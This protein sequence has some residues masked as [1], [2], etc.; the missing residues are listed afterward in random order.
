MFYDLLRDGVAV[1]VVK[2]NICGVR[3]ENINSKM[4]FL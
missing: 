4:L 3:C 2:N 1:L